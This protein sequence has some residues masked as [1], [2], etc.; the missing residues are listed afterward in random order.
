MGSLR[1]EEHKPRPPTIKTEGFEAPLVAMM[2]DASI[3]VTESDK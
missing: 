3:Q 1:I 2:Q